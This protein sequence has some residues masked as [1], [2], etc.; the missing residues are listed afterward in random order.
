[1]MPLVDIVQDT[2]E[3]AR[4]S[5]FMLK[6]LLTCGHYGHAVH[7]SSSVWDFPADVF[8][9]PECGEDRQLDLRLQVILMEELLEEEF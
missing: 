5:D 1:M 6:P 9:C 3:W 8:T 4:S 2:S 7:P